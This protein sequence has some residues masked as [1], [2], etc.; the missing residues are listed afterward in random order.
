[1][2]HTKEVNIR[3][4]HTNIKYYKNIGFDIKTSDIIVVSVD[5]LSNGS[6]AIVE[7]SC[8]D[9]GNKKEYPYVTYMRFV[10]KNKY[11]KYL[12]RKC[13]MKL[14]DEN[15]I[16][17]YGVKSPMQRKE[18]VEKKRETCLEKYGFDHPCKSE[19][20]KNKIFDTNLEKYGVQYVVQN[21]DI[22]IK[23]NNTNLQKYGNK[24]SLQGDDIK[25]KI[26]I[27]M[28]KKYGCVFYFDFDRQKY[29]NEIKRKKIQNIKNKYP[30]ILNIISGVTYTV[31]CDNEC[32]HDFEIDSH[33]FYQRIRYNTIICTICNPIDKLNSGK[34]IEFIK[35][36]SDNYSGK[37]IKNSRIL[38]GKEIDVFLPELNIGFEFNG[39]YW[40]SEEFKENN[41]HKDKVDLANTKGIKLFHVYEDDW[42]YKKDIMKNDILR[43]LKPIN[44]EK[45]NIFETDE[46]LSNLYIS[47]NNLYDYEKSNL[48]ICVTNS[49]N[50]I[51]N[52][53][54]LKKWKDKYQILRLTGDD[55]FDD[56]FKYLIENY[57]P[58]TIIGSINKDWDLY[59]FYE[60]NNFIIES[61]TEPTFNY[62]FKNG[63]KGTEID[64]LLEKQIPKIYNSGKINYKLTIS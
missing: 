32:E 20:V 34:E 13:G 12:C 51:I 63:H 33:N 38:D 9:C 7:V 16:E 55:Y 45:I 28:F 22:R 18:I 27:T 52:L 44:K 17:K 43:L 57:K 29:I 26:K 58:K 5:K 37:I 40:H 11:H 2:I 31:K 30:N 64:L 48:N 39:L 54:S 36:I 41:Y 1:M 25:E 14:K 46:E 35:F 19:L 56:I 50:E 59:N 6:H 62:I 53:M 49:D 47:N 8:D 15:N 42:T 61:E 23:I 10:N 4:N 3:I 60:R 21:K 24:S